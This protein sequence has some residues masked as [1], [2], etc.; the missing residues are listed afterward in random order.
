MFASLLGLV[1]VPVLRAAKH[2]DF[3]KNKK[4]ITPGSILAPLGANT[5]C[6]KFGEA[7]DKPG[8]RSHREYHNINLNWRVS[9]LWAWFSRG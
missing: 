8:R 9:P 2:G 7:P 1:F 5:L 4:I 3:Q 6:S